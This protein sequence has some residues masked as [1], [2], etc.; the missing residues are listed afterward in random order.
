[1]SENFKTIIRELPTVFDTEDVIKLENNLIHHVLR[2]PIF[3]KD[4]LVI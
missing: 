1:M 4:K 3:I 2:G